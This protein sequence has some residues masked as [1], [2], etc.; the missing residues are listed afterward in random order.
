ML[1]RVHMDYL[2]ML[3]EQQMLG[4]VA[5]GSLVVDAADRVP[6]ASLQT[7]SESSVHLLLHLGVSSLHRPQVPV[8]AVVPLD[9]QPGGF[10]ELYA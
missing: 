9:L 4:T 7:R 2:Q 3:T 1:T 5:S 6:A 8:A 10:R